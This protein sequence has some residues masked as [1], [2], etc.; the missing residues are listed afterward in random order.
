MRSASIRVARLLPALAVLLATVAAVILPAPP[1]A[2]GA[3]L[4]AAALV[5][6]VLSTVGSA[7]LVRVGLRVATN[8]RAVVHRAHPHPAQSD[9]DARGH[10]RPR[11][12]SC[13]L[14]AV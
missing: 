10:V 11:A 5:T 14:A 4:I 13:L 7:L 8:A 3:G 12:P 1:G 6:F 9:P 2:L